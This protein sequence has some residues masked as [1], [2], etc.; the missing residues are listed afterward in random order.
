[1]LPL[2]L[3]LMVVGLCWPQQQNRPN[4]R[5]GVVFGLLFS[6]QLVSPRIVS[7]VDEQQRELAGWLVNFRRALFAL[8]PSHHWQAGQ[9]ERIDFFLLLVSAVWQF[10]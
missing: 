10:V 2:N 1:M 9:R 8:K 3:A 4:N 5:L 6:A 7:A